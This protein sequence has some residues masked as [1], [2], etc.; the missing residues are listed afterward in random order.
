MTPQKP[1]LIPG[2]RATA[3]SITDHAL[4]DL[5]DRLDFYVGVHRRLREHL[6]SSMADAIT[7]NDHRMADFIVGTVRILDN[8]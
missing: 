1:R 7:I 6:I 2:E 8:R 3:S 5:Y 4:T